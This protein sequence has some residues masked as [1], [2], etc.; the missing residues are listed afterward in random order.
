MSDEN[1][2]EIISYCCGSYQYGD[3]GGVARYDY[4]LWKTFPNRKFF[5]NKD[6]L[7]SYL[8]T[9]KNPIVLADN[10]WSV[11]VPN[12]YECIIVHHGCALNTYRRNPG[13][14]SKFWINLCNNQ[15]QMLY[16][17][18]PEN[19]KIISISKACT[20]DFSE[21]FK[22][23]YR[24]FERIDLLH[25][26]E[27]DEERFKSSSNEKP[28]ILGNWS[29]VKKGKNYIGNIKQICKEFTFNNLYVTPVNGDIE[30]FN[31]RKQDIYLEND[32]FLQLSNSE[33][34]AY[35]TLDAL[36]CGLVVVATD[37]G[38][39]HGDIPEDCFV[40]LDW[41]KMGDAE[42]V[43]EKLEYAYENRTEIASKGREWYMNNCR[44][45][46]WQDKMVKLI[47]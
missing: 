8:E 23:S 38:L 17:R 4:Q 33:G 28:S 6:D 9:C 41:K 35:S 18:K 16:H 45:S 47:Q 3:Y 40:K 36:L 39:F 13:L 25:S 15:T 32:I 44:F 22:E 34:N 30:D 21:I 46:T 31:R 19:T 10:H 24:K 2:R 26:S 29:G 1:K 11:D 7:L 14:D 20:D 37:V 12:K 42:Y 5:N 43:K 27:L